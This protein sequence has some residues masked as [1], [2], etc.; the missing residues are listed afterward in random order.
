MPPRILVVEDEENIA[1]VITTA[2]YLA[3][4]DTAEA[5][6]GLDGL[7]LAESSDHFDL[8]IAD[9]MMPGID[10]FGLYRQLRSNGVGVPIVFLTARDGLDD[11]IRGLSLGIDAYFTKPF[12]IEELVARVRSILQRTGA[13]PESHA[14]TS[15]TLVL[16]DNSWRVLCGGEEID[17][18]PTEYRLLRYLIHNA[19]HV[20]SNRQIRDHVWD[21]GF[22]GDTTI[23]EV[24]VSS[25]RRKIDSRPPQLIHAVRGVGYRWDGR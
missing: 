13:T 22:T 11:R 12:R 5:D 3:G 18:T 4:F 10:G 9:V 16:D 2:L 15:G 20:M 7:R 1:Y 8:I 25:L 21:Y 23:V 6:N 19:G 24:V 14:L 17:L